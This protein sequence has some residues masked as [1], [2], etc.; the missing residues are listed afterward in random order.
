MMR[1]ANPPVVLTPARR[2]TVV[3]KHLVTHALVNGEPDLTTEQHSIACPCTT[4]GR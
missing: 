3:G 2:V 4:P 1:T